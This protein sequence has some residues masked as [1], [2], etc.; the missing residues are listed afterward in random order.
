[1]KRLLACIIFSIGLL[2][3]FPCYGQSL[4]TA[5]Y[6]INGTLE[7]PA[8]NPSLSTENRMVVFYQTSPEAGYAYDFSGTN[9]L[10]GR[11]KEFIINAMDDWRMSI[12]PGNYKVS[13]V[14]GGDNCGVNPT[15]VAVSGNGWDSAGS[16]V[17]A[18]GAGIASPE[19][20]ALPPG[21][22]AGVPVYE[23]IWFDGRVYQK[24]LVAKGLETLISAKPKITAKVVADLGINPNSISILLDEGT[25]G[26]KTFPITSSNFTLIVGDA[27]NPTEINYAF[28]FD[29][30]G[31]TLADGEH[32]FKFGAGNTLGST[33]EIATV[34]V[35]VGGP[36][37]L[38]G[39]PINY[40]SPVILS[41]DTSVTLQYGL[42]K[43][44]NIDIYIYDLT[45]TIVKKLSFNAG[46]PGGSAGGGA[47]PN[48]VTW[49]LFTDQGGLIGAGIYVWNIVDRESGKLLGAGK[50]AAAP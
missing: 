13:V 14:T 1:M 50:L 12:A 26:A 19:A 44:T 33:L 16:L 2:T 6:W 27:A 28:D 34:N 21:L 10:S 47:N 32:E 43:D 41:R 8:E 20:R 23:R 5:F 4:Y 45:G 40:P 49:N 46:E 11:P 17:L 9:G 30:A 7:A 36:A 25:A 42:T 37:Q 22:A 38:I 18:F 24:A 15:D 39:T 29:I 35:A 48:K 3:A 31:E